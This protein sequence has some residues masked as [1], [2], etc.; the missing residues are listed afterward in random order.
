[1][2]REYQAVKH[3]SVMTGA[4]SALVALL[5]AVPAQADP[6]NPDDLNQLLKTLNEQKAKINQQ[7]RLLRQQMQQLDQQKSALQQQQRQLDSLRAQFNRSIA[8]GAPA[9]ATPAASPPVVSPRT[10]DTLRG[11]GQPQSAQNQ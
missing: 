1:M 5:A 9:Q 8:A 3:F 7:E 11:T 2:R 10:L 4:A 6:V